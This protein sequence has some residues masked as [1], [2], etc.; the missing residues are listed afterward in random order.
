MTIEEAFDITL[1]A[2]K[3]SAIVFGFILVFEFILSFIKI[4]MQKALEKNKKISPLFGSLFGLI[5]QCGT[6]VL[7]AD[8]YVGR[9]ITMGTL[10]AIF[11]SC[12]DEAIPL[13]LSS[14]KDN[15]I[16]VLPLIG[17]KFMVGF[18][19]GFVLDLILSKQELHLEEEIEIEECHHH[20]P[21]SK[22]EFLEE[23][24]LHPLFHSLEIFI[25]VLIINMFFG[26]LIGFVGE[27][28]FSNFISSNKYLA[29]LFSTLIGIIPN[30]A[31]SIV[32]SEMFIDSHLSFG[33]LLSGLLVNAG[34]GLTVLF[35]KNKDI[36][37]IIII[38]STCFLIS[39]LAGYITCII[40][41]F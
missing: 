33:A 3:D 9:H 22:Q 11:L 39:L 37:G 1:D 36:K 18:I 10:V 35:K 28:S 23:H 32:I 6:S 34:I 40:I 41:G 24:I 4:K 14:G 12:S 5:P 15:A 8:L 30:C 13:L 26:F 16:M 20:H 29:P 2:L 17:I 38:I 27:E 19:T 7:G 25:Y 21:H 31:S